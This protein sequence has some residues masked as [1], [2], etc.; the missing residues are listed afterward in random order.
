[1]TTNAFAE[2]QQQA[3]DLRTQLQGLAQEDM[4]NQ[5]MQ[6]TE[7]SP[8]RKMQKL[9]SMQ[10]GQEINIPSYMVMGAIT[11]RLTDGRYAFTANQTEAPVFREGNVRCF[12]AADSPEREA[13][14]L[15]EAGLDHLSPCPAKGLRSDYSKE[16]HAKNRHKQSWET[17]QTFIN[18]KET[19]EWRQQAQAQTAATLELARAAAG[20]AEPGEQEAPRRIGRPPKDVE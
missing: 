2:Q 16:Q 5:V 4:G 9:W 15:S 1:M 10:D 7:W 14:L 8:G 12:L 19:R 20:R 6:F 3:R 11:K 18:R 17:L 13:G